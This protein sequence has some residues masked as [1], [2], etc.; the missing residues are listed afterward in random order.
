L[1]HAAHAPLPG[2]GPS[3][4]DQRS[5]SRVSSLSA[6]LLPGETAGGGEVHFIEA[7]SLCAAVVNEVSYHCGMQFCL[8]LVPRGQ[9]RLIPCFPSSNPRLPVLAHTYRLLLRTLWPNEAEPHAGAGFA[10]HG[11]DGE[12]A[13]HEDEHDEEE[14]EEEPEEDDEEDDDHEG[15]GVGRLPRPAPRVVTP[16][17]PAASTGIPGAQPTGLRSPVRTVRLSL[18]AGR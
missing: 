6:P 10:E 4:A 15:E 8:C 14:P 3:V 5:G 17:S 11:V 2:L 1:F 18:P 7:A 16:R 9:R 12:H 13:E